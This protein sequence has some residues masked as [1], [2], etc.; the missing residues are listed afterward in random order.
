MLGLWCVCVCVCVRALRT[1]TSGGTNLH[2]LFA[3]VD[4]DILKQVKWSRCASEDGSQRNGHSCIEG[5]E[6]RAVEP[7]LQ[8]GSH[9]VDMHAIVRSQDHAHVRAHGVTLPRRLLAPCT[10]QTTSIPRP[11]LR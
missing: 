5:K 11:R 8:A 7:S 3:Q 10:R 1:D 4:N 6:A 9:P 2:A